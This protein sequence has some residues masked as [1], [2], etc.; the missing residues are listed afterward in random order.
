MKNRPTANVYRYS[1][2][3]SWQHQNIIA[4][5]MIK[6]DFEQHK[7]PPLS[8]LHYKSHHHQRMPTGM[9]SNFLTSSTLEPDGSEIKNKKLAGFQAGRQVVIASSEFIT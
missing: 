4:A 9:R 8:W 5:K 7:P 1:S 3:K 2:A 6:C